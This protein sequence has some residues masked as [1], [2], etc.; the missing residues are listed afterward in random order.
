[1]ALFS[2]N[3]PLEGP[4]KLSTWR[5]MALHAWPFVS[6]AS[7]RAVMEIEA[8]AMLRY[9]DERSKASGT[10]IAPVHFVGR[11]LAATL[12][13]HPDINCII[14]R[15]RLYRRRDVD[16]MFPV[17]LDREGFDLAAAVVRHADQKSL[18][19]V[20][21]DLNQAAADMRTQGN[22]GMKPAPPLLQGPLLRFAQF[23]LY[24]LNL[25]SPALGM[26]QNA[27]GSAAV[28][29]VS[30][31]GADIVFPPLLPLARLPIVI[32]IGPV[33]E[34]Y[35]PDGK[36]TKW[37]RLFVVIDHRIIDGVYSGRIAHFIRGVFADPARYFEKSA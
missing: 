3:I 29:D 14:R 15:K 4:V 23:M 16:I 28:S 1:M 13:E 17:A 7:I 11:T 6:D 20:A 32:G 33:F 25:W 27:F 35:G 8:E 36:A 12:R 31:F 5:G 22:S 30:S 34:K 2:R 19:E 9:I 18:D 10:R 37:I 26:P 21:S 24:T